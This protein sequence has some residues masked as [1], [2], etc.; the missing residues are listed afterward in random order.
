VVIRAALA[1]DVERVVALERTTAEAPHWP[2]GEYRRLIG[3]Q[4]PEA[5]VRSCFFVAEVEGDLEGLAGFAVGRVVSGVGEL[6]SVAVDVRA[7][8]RGVGRRLCDA[9]VEWCRDEGAVAVELEVRDGGEAAR[10]LYVG[11]GFQET[12]RRR[13]YYRNPV[14]DAV[15]M[16]LRLG[17]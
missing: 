11:M 4:G 15:L 5:A 1:G 14:D 17:R 9:V 3:P 6:E 10:R 7:R 8:R 13:G 2:E 12:G 16:K